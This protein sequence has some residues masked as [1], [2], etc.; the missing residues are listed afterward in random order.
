MQ[1]TENTTPPQ[2]E[3][4]LNPHVSVDCVIFGFDFDGLKV[5]LIERK[6]TNGA[7]HDPDFRNTLL[8]G[9]LV[10]DDEDLDTSAKRVLYELTG[11][12]NIFLEQ[13]FAFGDPARVKGKFDTHWLQAI[14]EEPSARV[15]TVAYYS[16]VKLELYK[17]TASSF[18]QKAEWFPISAIPPLAFDHN[19][20]VE[21]AIKT[22]TNKLRTQPIGFELLPEKFTLGQMQK[23]YEV[24][25]GKELDKRNFRRKILNKRILI[26]L[27]EKQQGVPHKQ[28]QLFM[29]DREKYEDMKETSFGFDL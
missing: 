14:R 5:L 11:L 16:L 26:P 8:P 25:L 13:F 2:T 9:N 21:K 3:K 1:Q 19:A 10:K 15:I 7:S 29:F 24:I 28:A 23:L 20:I 22:L 18:A 17:P 27:V 12:T 4:N 6:P